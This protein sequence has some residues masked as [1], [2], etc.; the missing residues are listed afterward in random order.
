MNSYISK[1]IKINMIIF[2][3]QI[4]IAFSFL[5]FGIFVKENSKYNIGLATINMLFA[6][7]GLAGSNCDNK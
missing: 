5:S 7:V 2:I 3:L 1:G 4:L 6:F